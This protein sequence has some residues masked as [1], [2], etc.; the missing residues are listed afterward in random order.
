MRYEDAR[1][2]DT[3]GEDTRHEAA[4]RDAGGSDMELTAGD[5]FD[6][7][8]EQIAMAKTRAL[9]GETEQAHTLFEDAAREYAQYADIFSSL[10]G[11]LS[12]QHD[13]ETT[14]Q[15]LCHNSIQPAQPDLLPELT[16]PAMPTAPPK[17]RVRRRTSKAA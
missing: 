8:Y 7:L 6:A 5:L 12:L 14:R 2:E 11:H 3:R 15:M 4:Q 16:M 1:H 17:Q 10:P 13:L 9:M